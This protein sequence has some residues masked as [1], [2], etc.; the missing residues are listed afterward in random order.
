MLLI[1]VC[2]SNCAIYAANLVCIEKQSSSSSKKELNIFCTPICPQTDEFCVNVGKQWD[3]MGVGNFIEC[4]CKS[5][6]AAG[7]FGLGF[8]ECLG[9]QLVFLGIA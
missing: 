9:H 2:L 8:S 5:F 7:L 4:C 3:K 6:I 1:G